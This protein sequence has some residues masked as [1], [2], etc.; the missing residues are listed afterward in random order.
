MTN[1]LF[2][3]IEQLES[4]FLLSGNSA[5]NL[6]GLMP[7]NPALAPSSGASTAAITIAA[8]QSTP[9]NGALIP[10]AIRN[11]YGFNNVA[12]TPVSGPP[13]TGDGTGQT[14]AIIDWGNDPQIGNDLNVFEVVFECTGAEPCI[15]MA[16]HVSHI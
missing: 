15:Q 14:I 7:I 8:D 2:A 13:I 16:I 5:L 11:Y 6:S 1:K 4:R 10:S 9:V 12:F 3:A